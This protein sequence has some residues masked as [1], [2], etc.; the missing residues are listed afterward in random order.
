MV[1]VPIP[2]PPAASPRAL[3]LGERLAQVIAE[4]EAGHPDLSALELAQATQIAIARH[5]PAAPPAPLRA[6]MVALVGAIFAV[7]LGVTFARGQGLS[8]ETATIVAAVAIAA[9]LGVALVL[10]RR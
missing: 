3:E 2:V 6:V 8:G 4:Y 10:R 7:A 9:A 1:F 5:N